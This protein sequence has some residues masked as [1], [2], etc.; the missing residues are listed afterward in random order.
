LTTE[1]THKIISSELTNESLSLIKYRAIAMSKSTKNQ[2]LRDK[3]LAAV[4]QSKQTTLESLN[5]LPPKESAR[6]V[7]SEQNKQIIITEIDTVTKEDELALKV[8]FRLFPSKTAFSKIRS[9]LFF[10]GKKLNSVLI[11]IPQSPLAKDDFELTPV[12]DMKGITAGT[13]S[14]KV[15]MYEPWSNEEKLSF[16]QK[17]VTVEYVPQTRESRL[18]EIPIVKS[19]G[20]GDLAVASESDKNIYH[21]IEETMKK[22]SAAKRDEW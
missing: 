10:N 15:E 3:M 8:E 12:L 7:A 20:G 2:H 14:I 18:I 5:A 11:T 21:E 4:K 19:I 17:E 6:A 9:D 13:H 16:T 22:E 1:N